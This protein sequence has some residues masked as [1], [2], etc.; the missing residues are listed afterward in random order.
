MILSAPAL[1]PTLLTGLLA[2][3]TMMSSLPLLAAAPD[4]GSIL[5]EIDRTKPA[6]APKSSPEL[7]KPAPTDKRDGEARVVVEHFAFTGN[8]HI[9]SKE[10][11]TVVAGYTHRP[12]TFAELQAA[13]DAIVDYH[14]SK[15]WLVRTLLPKQDITAGTVT[16][17][18]I[19]A[20]F[21]GTQ[22]TGTSRRVAL[23]RIERIIKSQN[24][25]ANALSL[26][27]LERALLIADD[28]P[29][30]N[31]SGRLIAGQQDNQTD[32]LLAVSDEPLVNGEV[33]I[34]NWGSRST[35]E[36]RATAN[37]LVNSP[38]GQGDQFS[39]YALHTQG[40]DFARLGLTLPVGYAG[41]RLGV[42]TSY[43]KYD[44]IKDLPGK[45]TSTTVGLEASYPI[46]RSRFLNLN[47]TA[48]LDRKTFDNHGLADVLTS[49]YHSTVF[50]TGLSGNQVDQSGQGALTNAA[51]ILSHGNIDL[52]GSPSQAADA[53]GTKAQGH[54]TKLH[55]SI[56]RLHNLTDSTSL[57]GVLQGQFASKNL[58]SSEKFYLGGPYGVRAY[59][60]NEGGGSAGHLLTAE[61][62]QTLPQN[63][64]LTGFYDWGHVTVNTRNSFSGAA[65][66][67]ELTY[68]G[69]GL[70]LAWAGPGNSNLK[71]T[72]SRRLGHNPYPVPATG[73]DQDGS[74]KDNRLWLTASLQF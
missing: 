10:L 25:T 26:T 53:A 6:P 48:N 59:P 33:G 17:Q 38:L 70:S 14:A 18:V 27:S 72:W 54:F 34:D 9:D 50:S 8:S 64:L 56:N 28:L 45:G 29:G 69:L 24:Q 63:L 55:Y 20:V 74:K 5:Q 1:R 36:T 41:L 40:T 42:N 60:N 44:L 23:E 43:L 16:I 71:A 15:G 47:W 57:Y 73:N 35:D 67:N 12:V 30:V 32:V 7:M 49:R 61:I 3:L 46:V 31:V 37:L 21:G 39:T 13:A 51:L 19:E 2:A 4:A 62:R 65:N 68:Q 52:N 58:D 22:V 11:E 66:P